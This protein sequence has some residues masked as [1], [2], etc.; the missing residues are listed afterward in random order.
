MRKAEF[1]HA[2]HEA[3]PSA[4]L[5]VEIGKIRRASEAL[6]VRKVRAIMKPLYALTSIQEFVEEQPDYEEK[7]EE[8]H[9]PSRMRRLKRPMDAIALLFDKHH[10][11]LGEVA[12]RDSA[13]VRVLL[14]AEGERQIGAHLGDWQTRGVPILREVLVTEP[15]KHS[16]VYFQE[17]VQVRDREFLHALRRWAEKH[18]MALVS[19][20]P[21]ALECW[22]KITRLP[23]EPRER[24]S[25]IV[26]LRATTNG[27]LDAWK[28]ALQEASK[29]VEAEEEKMNKAIAALRHR[30]A[31]SLAATFAKKGRE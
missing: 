12:T 17:R 21:E 28:H 20:S 13:M 9:H 7:L 19:V 5:A 3:P 6:S 16:T 25:M 11:F 30:S 26:A 4:D 31:K 22:E 18:G 14:T 24:F 27:E 1:S 15:Q 8:A 2:T 23:V 10:A 29:A